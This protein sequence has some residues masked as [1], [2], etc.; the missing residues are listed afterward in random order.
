[1]GLEQYNS[2]AAVPT[3]NRNNVHGLPVVLPSSEVLEKFDDMVLPMFE[4]KKSLRER[5]TT[6]RRTRDLLLPR[7]ISGEVAVAD[8]E[9]IMDE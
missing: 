4:L 1:M 6:L 9:I 3:L 7:L 5:N 2:G 8:L